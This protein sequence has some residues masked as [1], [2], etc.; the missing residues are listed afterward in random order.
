LGLIRWTKE[1][2]IESA[3]RFRTKYEWEKG[4]C[5]AYQACHRRGWLKD[6]DITGHMVAA[7]ES[8]DKP[9]LVESAR[10]FRTKYEWEK[11]AK[12]AYIACQRRGWLEDPDITGHMPV[13]ENWDK[14]KLVES[15]RRFRTRWKWQRGDR[16][17]YT[18]CMRRGWLEDPDITG[19][20]VAGDN[21]SDNDAVYLYRFEVA[22]VVLYKV[23]LTSLSRGTVRICRTM[24]KAGTTAHD[25]HIWPV[26]D[27]RET[28]RKMLE[29]G[30]PQ[31]VYKG[32]GHTEM[33]VFTPEEVRQAV[34]L[35]EADST[36]PA[37]LF[38]NL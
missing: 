29:L 22:R 11:G 18:A 24:R 7:H 32:D 10:R 38:E 23:G 14:P 28:E 19:H 5:K 25:V 34:A 26:D 4:D 27:A 20:M 13:L 2:L 30:Q 8:W 16:N 33:R 12:N 17:S 35:A 37:I 21:A 36:G 15:A 9:K 3:R 1:L 31:N 6:P